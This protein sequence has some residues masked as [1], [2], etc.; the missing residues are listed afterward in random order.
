MLC[1][2][3]VLCKGKRGYIESHDTVRECFALGQTLTEVSLSIAEY[4][5]R[6]VS[7]VMCRK[8]VQH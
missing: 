5:E 2:E 6:S 8:C 4:P 1:E 7:S 3:E